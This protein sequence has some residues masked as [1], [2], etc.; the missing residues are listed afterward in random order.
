MPKPKEW[1]HWFRVATIDRMF[2][3]FAIDSKECDLWVQAFIEARAI[4]QQAQINIVNKK[5]TMQAEESQMDY[6]W[7]ERSIDFSEEHIKPDMYYQRYK[8]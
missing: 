1:S 4:G 8:V 5:K 7:T 6:K 3:L 2:K